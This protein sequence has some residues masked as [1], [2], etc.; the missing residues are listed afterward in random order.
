M[1][2]LVNAIGNVD[3]YRGANLAESLNFDEGSL[4]CA[5][6]SCRNRRESFMTMLRE[7]R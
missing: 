1:E 6:A 7:E 4:G 2:A 5:H 3:F